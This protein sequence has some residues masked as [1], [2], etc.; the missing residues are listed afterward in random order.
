MKKKI[1]VNENYGVAEFV[2]RYAFFLFIGA[3]K[4]C[5]N[6]WTTETEWKEILGIFVFYLYTHKS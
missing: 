3:I 6:S 5:K 1:S 4:F 2:Y